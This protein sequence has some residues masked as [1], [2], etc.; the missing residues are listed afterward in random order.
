MA[1]AA[2][3]SDALGPDYQEAYRPPE[4]ECPPAWLP[5]SPLVLQLLAN[6]EITAI[7]LAPEGSNYTFVAQLDGGEAGQWLGIY[8][9]RRGEIPLRDFPD[10]TLYKRE[11]A[12]YVVSEALGWDFVPPTVVREGQHGVGTMQLFVASV[13]TEN[14]F[15]FREQRVDDLQRMALFDALANNADRKGS[16]CLL[17]LDG[18]MWGIDHGLT[19]HHVPKL[20]TVI[21]DY[22]GTPIPQP[23]LADL[24]G[25]LIDLTR[26]G[27]AAQ[28]LAPLLHPVE[29]EALAQRCRTLLT[30]RTYPLPGPYRSVPWPPL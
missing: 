19:F 30:E 8:K 10:G 14:Y 26:N 18:R 2:D 3:Y 16:H 4:P 24:D 22:Q 7:D 28:A 27:E 13:R 17:G 23:L 21:W 9:P 11:Y 20:R 6:A 25:F 1:A 15:S 5:E 29:L 12:A